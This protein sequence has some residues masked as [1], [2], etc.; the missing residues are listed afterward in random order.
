MRDI[1]TEELIEDQ[2]QR[3]RELEASTTGLREKLLVAKQ[4]LV[5]GGRGAPGGLRRS[6]A[7]RP[8]PPRTPSAQGAAPSP[9]PLPQHS[10]ASSAPNTLNQQAHRLL[11]EARQE[12]RMMEEALSTFKEQVNIYEQEVD[13]IKEQARIK[14]ANFEEEISILKSQVTD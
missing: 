14:E 11:E 9:S 5:G 2:Q 12:N 10:L 1:E 7:R 8:G 3:I 13:Q 6:P 4:Q